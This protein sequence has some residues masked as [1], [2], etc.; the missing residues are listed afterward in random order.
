MHECTAGEPAD[1]PLAGYEV[2]TNEYGNY[3]IQGLP[4]GT[5]SLSFDFSGHPDA[6]I[7]RYTIPGVEL[8]DVFG[9]D[10]D[11]RTALNLPKT[12]QAFTSCFNWDPDVKELDLNTDAGI[13]CDFQLIDPTGYIYCE[14]SGEILEGVS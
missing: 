12:S 14:S 9:S 5:Y 2:Q 13:V 11:V 4:A 1:E 3:I 10:S 8:G 7:F 6:P